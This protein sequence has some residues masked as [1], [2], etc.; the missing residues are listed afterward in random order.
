MKEAMKKIMLC[1]AAGI[2]AMG[3]SAQSTSDVRIYINPGHGSWGPNDRPMPTIPYPNLASTG[4]PDTCGF[5]ESNTDLWKCLKLGET[6][7][8]M[9][10]QKKNIMYSRRLNGPYPYVSGASDAEKYNRSLSEISA[11]VDANNMDMFISIHSNAATDGT[12]TNYPLILYR[13]KD[14]DGGDYAQGSRNICKALWKPHYMDELDPQ[15]A[16]SRTSMNIRGDIDF[17]HTSWTNWKGYEGY[18]GV[19]MHSVP[20]CLIEGFFHTYQPARHRAL[21]K[22][23]CGQ[24]GVRVA[25]GICD[26]FK[27]SP[28]KTGYIMGTV[29]DMHEKI[30]NNL[31]N[32]APNTND[33]WLPVNGAKVLL[34][35]G[36]ETVQTYQVDKLYNGIFVFEGLE[37]GDYTLEVEANGY[38][39]LTDEYKKPVTVKANETSYVKLLVE[40]SSY[41]PPVI[42]YKNY[43]DPEQPE[44]LKLPAQFKFARTSKNFTNFK[45]TL[46]RAI[47]R[48]DSAVVLADNA[49]TP[50]LH[51]INL[52]TNAYV[53]KLSTTGIIAKDASNAGDYS[54]LS[55]IAFT[56]DGKLVGVNS[57]LNQYSAS[58]V[59]AGYKQG[60][61]RIYKWNDFNSN[62]SLWASTQSSANFYRAVVG[63]S[64]A[65]SGESK[66]CTIITTATTTGDSKGTRML[67]LNVVDNTISSTV[68]TEKNIG[69][70]GNF[71][72]KKQGANL[73]LTVSPL[74]D[75]KFV[76]DGELRLPQEFTPA[77]TSNNDSEMSP[78]FSENSSYAIG[79]GAT[80]I[81]FFKYA[82]RSLMVAP[83]VNG[84]SVGGLRL[85]DVTDGMSA[86][87]PVA[88]NSNFSYPASAL[89]FMA[90]GAKV[91]GEDLTL[92]MFTGNKLT[93][94]TTKNVS[95]PVVKGITAYDL[96]YSPDGEGN[97]T[98][99]FTANT[100]PLEA[101]IVFYD[102]QNG[103]ALDSVAVNAP[104]E[105]LNTVKIAY[106]S[107]P[108]AG[109]EGVTWAV[110]LKGAPVTNIVRLNTAGASTNYDGKVFC[111]VD[112]SPES[113][114]F[115]R[116]YVM[117]YANYGSASNGLY[118]YTPAGVRI[119]STPYRGG[120]N[121]TMCYRISV[122]DNGN[123]YMSDYS[124]NTSGV[125]VGNPA[126]LT[127]SFTP[128]FTGTRNS[129]GLISNGNTKVGSSTPCVTVS[130]GKMYVLLEDFGNNVGVYNIGTGTSAATTWSKSP[131]K[132]FNVGS[133]LLNG[134]GQV[135]AGRNGGVWVSQLRY[136]NNNTQGVPSLI[137]VNSSGSVVFNSGK[138]DFADNL[139]GSCGS[140][141][142]VSPDNK[143]LVI[144]DGDGV[145]RFFDVTWSG[146][147][148]K[149]TPK[150][151]YTADV[152]NTSDHNGIYQMTFDY[153]GNLVCSGSSLGIYSI[154]NDRNETLVPARKSYAIVNAIDAPRMN[155]D[156]GVKYDSENRMVNASEGVKKITV[157]DAAGATV[158]SAA[159]N[160]LSLSGLMPGVYMIKA[161]NSQAV[162]IMVR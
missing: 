159:G 129:D 34:K 114:Y 148:P 105:G 79:E 78:E 56:A 132:Q 154:P 57:M 33:Q 118:A 142:A 80:G 127:G 5:Y 29:K 91:D 134:D 152:R 117:N 156:E 26:Y 136:V 45:G 75:D 125:Y 40:S 24:E 14:G 155:A 89:P 2:I 48:G 59:D 31:F 130:D 36:D 82:G 72:E 77:K 81:S 158:L 9:G 106:E 97:C 150:Y 103:K 35:K 119:N 113:E 137:Y 93:K 21:N 85:Y 63:K 115:G 54:T 65:I 37:P 67:M 28:E 146:S 70:D 43:P 27:L 124:D 58:Q 123:I 71:S 98:F 109:D 22:D 160:T 87:V 10:V 138:T 49:G 53:K 111:A 153:G 73:Q 147:I 30:A 107:I 102:P 116:M 8:K 100:Q 23:Y 47:V 162:K 131:S 88:T 108:K 25:R 66:D 76:I 86:A 6:L 15:S 7:E 157:Y 83:Y 60:T 104:K 139:N 61:L 95:Q 135:V 19:L 16:Y 90:S 96:K 143:L 151:S 128:F 55:D 133:L 84:T 18:L 94:F 42:V 38:K 39:S 69:A 121:L 50:E 122:G 112:N 141:F 101:S 41:A 126:N 149:L 161:D 13:G 11:E 144:N 4:R 51:L 140:G 120:Q 3:A 74:A 44:Y 1:F 17:Y 62:P 110:R 46:K 99:N 12:T 145:L 92:Y 32:Y 20:G 52:K 68:F 64:L